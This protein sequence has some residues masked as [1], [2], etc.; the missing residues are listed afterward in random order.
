MKRR[1]LEPKARELREGGWGYKEVAIELKMSERQIRRWFDDERTSQNVPSDWPPE[2][3]WPGWTID[4]LAGFGLSDF[5]RDAWEGNLALILTAQTQGSLYVGWFFRRLVEL[6]QNSPMPDGSLDWSLA[7]A[8]LPV[9]GKWLDCPPCNQLAELIEKQQPWQGRGRR[10]AYQRQ[11]R[12]VG[13]AVKQCIIAA[14]AQTVAKDLA[15]N[16]TSPG[17]V[18]LAAQA[19]RNHIIYLLS[20]T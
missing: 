4:D 1:E 6:D 16:R 10:A 3:L 9:L 20:R 15:Q 11:S 18:L 7:L 14:Q 13:F 19:E 17:P 5:K 12:Q 8:A 2:R